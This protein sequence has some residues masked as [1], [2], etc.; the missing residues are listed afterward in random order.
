[1]INKETCILYVFVRSFK[2]VWVGVTVWQY[3]SVYHAPTD[4]FQR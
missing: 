2:L 4:K 3:C 1:M